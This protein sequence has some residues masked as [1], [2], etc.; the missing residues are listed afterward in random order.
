MT[1][2]LNVL[3]K[4]IRSREAYTLFRRS[5]W[6]MMFV[7][8]FGALAFAFI[9]FAASDV[10]RAKVIPLFAIVM[11]AGWAPALIIFV[12]MLMYLFR[13]DRSSRRTKMSWMICLLCSACY[14]S[15]VYFF[16]VCR[17]QVFWG[18]G[19]DEES[20]TPEELDSLS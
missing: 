15:T 10:V 19:S 1:P 7:S 3:T 17:K 6:W 18:N 13:Y 4:D 14:G 2:I 12:G 9:V 16:L 20:D 11:V 5:A 8:A